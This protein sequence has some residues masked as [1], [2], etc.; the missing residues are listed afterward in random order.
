MA[1]NDRPPIDS[2]QPWPAEK[3]RDDYEAWHEYALWCQEEETKAG[4][5][6]QNISP[7]QL[8]GNGAS[9]ITQPP[10]RTEF[11]A[12]EDYLPPLS[13]QKLQPYSPAAFG[14]TLPPT[15]GQE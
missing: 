5:T 1:L 4:L 10:A 14:Q 15:A 3:D 11:Q 7:A 9:E 2:D 13:R 12:A 8:Y 6:S